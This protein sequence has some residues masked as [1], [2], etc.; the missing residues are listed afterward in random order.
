MHSQL[1]FQMLLPMR[2]LP[3]TTIA[4]VPKPISCYPHGRYPG[5]V[6][7]RRLTLSKQFLKQLLI[8]PTI[9]NA[10]SNE[11]PPQYDNCCDSK[12]HLMLSLLT[13]RRSGGTSLFNAFKA[14]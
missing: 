3:N 6:E 10:A 12:T 14:V 8:L 7:S 5:P 4:L 1:W 13:L 2:H 9:P 11:T